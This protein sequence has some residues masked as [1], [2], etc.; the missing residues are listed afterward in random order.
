MCRGDDTIGSYSS[1]GPTAI[2]FNAKPDLLAPGT[3]TVSLAVPGST[4]YGTHAPYLLPGSIDT[5]RYHD[6]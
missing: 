5:M 6:A 4:F 1:R 3:G 2:D